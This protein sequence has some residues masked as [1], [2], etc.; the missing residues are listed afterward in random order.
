MT[1]IDDE[2]RLLCLS[3]CLEFTAQM[4]FLQLDMLKELVQLEN[5]HIISRTFNSNTFT[6]KD[7][8]CNLLHDNWESKLLSNI[9]FLM[10]FRTVS[11]SSG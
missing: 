6:L 7:T 8:T 10:V 9:L 1:S 2:K 4:L 5:H 11:W 3:L